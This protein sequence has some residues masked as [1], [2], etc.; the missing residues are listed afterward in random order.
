MKPEYK[1]LSQTIAYALRHKPESYGLVLD[2][3]GWV[4]LSDLISALSRKRPDWR[5]LTAEDIRAMAAAADKHRYE[6]TADRIRALYGHSLAARIEQAH[7]VPPSQLFHG[8]TPAA[9]AAIRREGLRAMRRQYVHLSLDTETAA[10]V[11]RRRTDVPV[12]IA[13][14]ARAAHADGVQFYHANELVWLSG[15][16]PP[17]YL[18]I[19]APAAHC[20]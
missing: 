14:D 16:I 1:R 2:E 15:C 20:P 6:I 7:A 17:R 19:P 11:A 4:P 8:T 12:I 5:N 3:N 18:R 13:V 10:E 9:V